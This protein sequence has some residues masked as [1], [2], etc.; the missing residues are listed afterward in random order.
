MPE[1]IKGG[2]LFPNAL[3]LKC[4]HIRPAGDRSRISIDMQWSGRPMTR[5]ELFSIWPLKAEAQPFESSRPAE[6]V[7][8]VLFSFY[9]DAL[10]R[11]LVT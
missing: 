9:N 11:M 3:A 1:T 2:T 4:T 6:S 10:Y 5:D 8:K 7:E